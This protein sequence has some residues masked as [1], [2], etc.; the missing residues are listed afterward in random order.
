MTTP[1]TPHD[2]GDPVAAFAR[3][4]AWEK[5][6]T[7]AARARR[8]SGAAI[9][10]AIAEVR[11][12][13]AASGEWPDDA[14]GDPVDYAESL[15]LPKAARFWLIPPVGFLLVSA[16]FLP[17]AIRGLREGGTAEVH[18]YM[19]ILATLMLVIVAAHPLIRGPVAMWVVRRT[20]WVRAGVMVAFVGGWFLLTSLLPTDSFWKGPAFVPLIAGLVCLAIG[21]VAGWR[22]LG[23]PEP[24]QDPVGEASAPPAFDPTA[25]RA[26]TVL[27]LVLTFAAV[28]FA[29]IA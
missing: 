7:A 10:A 29:L 21:V 6:F 13:C 19:V 16:W 12:H 18:I 20:G 24:V 22:G 17:P 3:V 5:R 1:P 23:D 2:W 26:V 9:G 15:D 4:Q 14:F 25:S 11:S 27:F 8:A 28:V